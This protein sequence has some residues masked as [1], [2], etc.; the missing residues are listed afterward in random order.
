MPPKTSDITHTNHDNYGPLEE[1]TARRARR[2]VAGYAENPEESLELMNML[3]VGL[4]DS[5]E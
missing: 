2:V 4:P 5:E 1:E 3:G